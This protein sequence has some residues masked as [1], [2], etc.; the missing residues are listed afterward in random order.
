MKPY[1]TF[2]CHK[3]GTSHIAKGLECEDY[4]LKY[5]N[6][7]ISVCAVSDGH[8]DKNCF[9]S[10]RGAKIAC[11]SAIRQI[12][13]FF[14]YKKETEN[15][16]KENPDITLNQLEKSIISEWTKRVEYD[17]SVNPFTEKELSPLADDI[18]NFYKSGTRPQK[19]YGCT[20]IVSAITDYGWFALQ[21]GDGVCTAIFDDGVYINPVPPDD[22]CVGNRS[23]SICSSD[24][25]RS[26]RHFYGKV[27]PQA[28]FVTSDGIEESFSTKDLNKCYYTISYWA[29]TE[30]TEEV[31]KRLD[32]LLPQISSGGSGDDVSLSFIINPSYPATQAKQSIEEINQRLALC[33]EH[34]DKTAENYENSL[35]SVNMLSAENEE[36]NRLIAERQSE[37]DALRKKAAENEEK[38]QTFDISSAKQEYENAAAQYEK[39]LNFKKSAD[40][41]WKNKNTLLS[42]NIP[43]SEFSDE[44]QNQ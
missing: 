36:I 33:L 24:A 18:K 27:L 42:L 26:F 35:D 44:K 14:S 41:F 1:K 13:V 40:I 38:L 5:E 17:I 34:K 28:V 23:A 6:E 31:N 25:I 15:A 2:S 8:G 11:E 29:N 16:L 22:D 43:D 39:L 9:R 21:T 30:N 7:K 19:A 4:S 37:I 32:T 20:L 10:G 3:I 12:K